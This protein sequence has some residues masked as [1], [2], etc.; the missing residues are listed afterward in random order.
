M[1]SGPMVREGHQGWANHISGGALWTPPHVSVFE[2]RI[3]ALE[4]FIPI[5]L[6]SVILRV[7]GPKNGFAARKRHLKS[8]KCGRKALRRTNF[9]QRQHCLL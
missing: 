8:V 3:R 1:K 5:K 4:T 7:W 6:I 9:W 2:R